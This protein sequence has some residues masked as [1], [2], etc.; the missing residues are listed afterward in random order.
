MQTKSKLYLILDFINGGHLFYH[1]YRQGIF[2]YNLQP[3]LK[4]LYSLTNHDTI[5]I[6]FDLDHGSLLISEDQAR[7]YAAEIVSAVSHLHNCG[8]VH[9]DLKPENILMDADGHVMSSLFF[10]MITILWWLMS[11]LPAFLNL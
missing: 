11:F 3:Q 1:L 10:Q 7:V 6:P 5:R 2:R 4:S 8:I 9:R